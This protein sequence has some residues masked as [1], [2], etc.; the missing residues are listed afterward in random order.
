MSEFNEHQVDAH[1]TSLRAMGCAVAVL[2][3]EDIQ[4]CGPH[5]DNDDPTITWEQA[6]TW[7]T[8]HQRDVEEAL[9]GDYWGETISA[10]LDQHPIKETTDA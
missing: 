2:T 9:L 6:A 8:E 4:T 10:L 1:I 7:L 3:P 5:D